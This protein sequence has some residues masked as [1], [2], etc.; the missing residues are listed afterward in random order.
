MKVVAHPLPVDLAE[1]PGALLVLRE[2]AAAWPEHPRRLRIHGV[3]ETATGAVVLTAEEPPLA[4]PDVA[5]AAQELD[6]ASRT[7]W[8]VARTLEIASALAGLG[9]AHRDVSP[10]TIGFDADGRAVLY[11]PLTRVTSTRPR[12][13][14]GTVKGTLFE[15]MS[16]EAV[17]GLPLDATSDV[18][19]LGMTLYRLLG[20]PHAFR[21][22]SDLD[23]LSAVVST[24]EAPAIGVDLAGALEAAIARAM[25]K[26][27]G[28]R[29]STV[30]ELASAIAPYGAES[31]DAREAVA[32]RARAMGKPR[33]SRLFDG[34]VRRPCLKRWD[35][36]APTTN[37]AVRD[38][39]TC[40]L[41]VQRVKT[42]AA[43]VPLEGS[44][45]F[46]DPDP[47]P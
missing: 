29:F 17:R 20:G 32:A 5:T 35:E 46:Y 14:A 45:V 39:A 37:D 30:E 41:A 3:D 40:A 42:L 34:V 44:C 31:A 16:P 38:C 28:A 47:D 18:Y 6:V 2:L 19:Q 7:A 43:L 15:W 22:P 33:A 1:D 26:S 9:Y 25:K 12:M 4:F 36:L 23:T 8:A 27:A 10:R 13:G 21:G 24:E 11:P